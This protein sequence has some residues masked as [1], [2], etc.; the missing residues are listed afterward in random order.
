MSSLSSLSIPSVGFFPSR[1]IPRSLSLSHSFSPSL[2]RFS[3]VSTSL[4]RSLDPTPPSLSFSRSLYLYL[5]RRLPSWLTRLALYLLSLSPFV[6]IPFLLAPL[7]P[8]PS[9]TFF[10]VHLLRS[11]SSFTPRAFPPLDPRHPVFVYL[12]PFHSLLVSRA[13]TF[14]D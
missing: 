10:S 14:S 2:F 7:P 13:P 8:S 5:S 4:S 12:M 6:P 9:A 11:L 1:A 3:S